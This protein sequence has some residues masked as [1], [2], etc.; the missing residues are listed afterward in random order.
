MSY[1][2][3]DLDPPGLFRR[4]LTYKTIV[5][6]YL[7]ILLILWF[8]ACLNYKLTELYILATENK[9]FKIFITD[10]ILKNKISYKNK[11]YKNNKIK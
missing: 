6:V 3:W 8:L 4:I 5:S 11:I 1:L 2:E 10:K 7:S 9:H